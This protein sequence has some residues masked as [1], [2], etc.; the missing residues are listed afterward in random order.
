MRSGKVVKGAPSGFV[1]SLLV[2]A[3]AVLL[4]GM[5]VVFTV[6][7]KPEQKFV[8][9]KP[10]EKPK[11]KLKK[12]MVKVKKSAA[13]KATS[14]IVAKVRQA[15]MPDIR[16][17][18]MSGMSGELGAGGLGGMDLAIL[19]GLPNII[20]TEISAGN[21]LVGTFYSIMRDNNGRE[22]PYSKEAHT[23]AIRKFIKGGWRTT[24]LSRYYRSPKR[25]YGSMVVV[26]EMFS[27]I[28]PEAFGENPKNSQY[29]MVHYTGQLVYP[30]DITFR[31]VGQADSTIAVRLGGQLVFDGWWH[32]QQDAAAGDTWRS[33][34]ADDRK[35]WMGNWT[36]TVGDW[37]TLKA[38]EPQNIDILVADAGGICCLMLGIQ[39]QGVEYEIRPGG[40][41]RLPAFK[42]AYPSHDMLDVVMRDM[43]PGELD[44]T[45]GPVF[46]DFRKGDPSPMAS[47]RRAEQGQAAGPLPVAEP[48]VGLRG[49][50]LADGTVMECEFIQR[51]GDKAVMKDASGKSLR[52]PLADLSADDLDYIELCNPPELDLSLGSSEDAVYA[53]E[54]GVKT[55]VVGYDQLYTGKVR[56]RDATPYRHQLTAEFY[57]IGKQRYAD[58]YILLDR[59]E[60]SFM[61]TKENNEAHNFSGRKVH[62]RKVEPRP[63]EKQDLTVRGEEYYG[64][65]M[66]VKDARGVVIAHRETAK[67]LYDQYGK[68][69]GFP[70]G[71]YL[72]EQGDRVYPVGP[73]RARY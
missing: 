10:V 73:P 37:V 56:K 23:E 15:H 28:A 53:W 69:Q 24:A 63:W 68:L 36:A 27:T 34:S 19:D 58:T 62:L 60:S 29:W 43:V 66:V 20:G 39:V 2:H 41:P 1:I 7:N 17:P 48:D 51:M 3:G 47:A 57:A 40:G 16:L 70:V 33:A 6:V 31:F 52:I 50:T 55:E 38:N 59:Q 13:P 8:P 72:N 54:D 45:N 4:A 22:I 65:L 12:P 64:Y 67:W 11:M 9:P 25:L 44:L 30:E 35:W 5:L 71:R 61:L 49:W 26:P 14:R 42:T 18:E 46:N 32:A 21:D